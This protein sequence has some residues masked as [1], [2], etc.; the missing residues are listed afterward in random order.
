MGEENKHSH[1]GASSAYRWMNCPGS[2][3]LYDQV[4]RRASSEYAR[5]G[6]A[7]HEIC[8]R[9]LLKN[10]DAVEFAGT[11]VEVEG[12]AIPVDDSMVSAVQVY[13][14]KIRADQDLLGGSLSVE[15]SFDLSWVRPGMF[16][17]NDACLVPDIL[18]G[19]L[20]VYDYKNGR[21]PVP[22]E[23]NLQCMYYA[24]GALGEDNPRMVEVVVCTIIQPNAYGKNPVDS[25]VVPVG[26]LYKWAEEELGP[27]VDRTKDPDAPCIEGEWCCFCEAAGIC[28]AKLG[29]ALALLD[30]PETPDVLAELP[31]V[32]ALTPAQVGMA[33]AFFTSDAFSAWVKSLAAVELDLL[34]RG[35]E[36]PGR[37]LVETTS[38]GNRKWADPAAVMAHPTLT[39]FGEELIESKLKSPSQVERLLTQVRIPRAERAAIMDALVTREETTKISVVSF[40][41]SR[42]AIDGQ[43][44]INLLD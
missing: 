36:V 33:S 1:I 10:C 23:G 7:A 32:E 26:D 17:R 20:H 35:V 16:G 6:T 34:Q 24:L 3:R 12:V 28:P 42:A 15:Q 5:V 21:K 43:A 39:V 37:K 4:P 41:D 25:W 22:A 18:F 9:C 8:E 19:T 44:A 2:V 27:A 38:Y 30:E 14:D 31:P 40:D 29:A 11:E 13:L